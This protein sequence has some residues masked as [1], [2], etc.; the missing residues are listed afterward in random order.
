MAPYRLIGVGLTMPFFPLIG[1]ALGFLLRSTAGAITAVL[2]I[3]WLPDMFGGLLPMWWPENVLSLLPG[4]P[5]TAR[6][7]AT[8]SSRAASGIRPQAPRSPRPGW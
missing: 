6:S 3:I 7:S 5:W 2:A 4:R 8:S 1:L